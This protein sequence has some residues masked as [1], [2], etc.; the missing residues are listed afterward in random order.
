MK[1]VLVTGGYGWLDIGDEAM[2]RTF[3]DQVLA[4]Y[5]EV[6]FCMISPCPE[7]TS[8]YHGVPAVQC[9]QSYI[10]APLG[11]PVL[12]RLLPATLVRA[13]RE[14]LVLLACQAP[15]L[16]AFLP[17]YVRALLDKFEES[18]L[19]LNVGGG[20]INS[21]IPTELY[22]KTFYWKLANRMG[23]QVIVSGQNIGPFHEKKHY[24]RVMRCLKYVSI[25]TLR[26][27]NISR[28]RLGS[29]APPSL[30]MFDVG[31]DAYNLEA[32]SRE[33]ALDLIAQEFAGLTYGER[34]WVG[35]NLKASLSAFGANEEALLAMSEK[36]A[37]LLDWIIE[38]YDAHI[39]M[40]PTDYT[41]GVDDRKIHQVIAGQMKYP[42]HVYSIN[43]VYSDREL[44]AIVSLCDFALASRYHCCVFAASAGVPF[45]GYAS[46]SYQLTK[47]Q[48]LCELLE[49]PELYI[50][51]DFTAIPLETLT[52]RLASIFDRLPEIRKNLQANSK[53]I[54]EN[55]GILPRLV[56]MAC[57]QVEN[58]SILD[59]DHH[60]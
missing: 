20:N 58:P 2:P 41:E 27:R 18:F 1:R 47:I 38:R 51:D 46:G 26:D 35:F 24:R 21:I 32:C 29:Q 37:S 42:R 9:L 17:D 22:L 28:R 14:S 60:R 57:R 15:G 4:N 55:T 45:F 34:R 52:M 30:L 33:R 49:M 6:E 5:P 43:N 16:R 48:G 19:F 56:A 53:M 13:F 8:R 59:L 12:R 31:D 3:M 10:F 50:S 39:L 44:K 36:C 7:A 25:M 23:M 40:I 11:I 54:S